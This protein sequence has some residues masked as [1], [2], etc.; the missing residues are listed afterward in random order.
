[1]KTFSRYLL[2]ATIGLLS[3]CKSDEVDFTYLPAEP[4]AGQT[5]AFNNLTEEGEEWLWEF[6]DGGESTLKNPSKTY[7]KPG[8]Y[9]ITLTADGK[10]HRKCAKEITVYDTIPTFSA[11]TDEIAYRHPV[12]FTAVAYN[13]YNNDITY[14]WQLPESAVITA[15]G[16][17]ENHV[18]VYFIEKETD[19]DITL[20]LSIGNTQNAITRSFHICDS[21]APSLLMTTGE[22][23]LRQRLYDNGTETPTSLE[24]N[25][26]PLKANTLLAQD[27]ILYIFTGNGSE[28]STIYAFDMN[29]NRL[30]TVIS[31]TEDNLS[32]EM[33]A[34]TISEGWLYWGGYNSIYRISLDTRNAV[35][36]T[37]SDYLFAET[38]PFGMTSGKT[39]GIAVCGNLWLWSTGK[40]ICRFTQTK[41]NATI[42]LADYTIN[43]LAVDALA[44]KVYF[45]ANNSLFVSNT[46]GTSVRQLTD[47]ATGAIAIDNRSNRIY[48]AQDNGIACLPLLQTQNN[49]TTAEPLQINNLANITAL[50]TDNTE[51]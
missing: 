30:S 17:T 3:A 10:A 42:L 51:R 40:G 18:T 25:A 46:D 23:L 44:R 4:R 5:I 28:K 22:G 7:K 49:Q 13:P 39:T 11:S 38:I 24:L 36:S 21:P 26:T 37:S 33:S 8:V 1:M 47:N 29:S 6:G 12:T 27:G 48:F 31:S 20:A 43:S 34:G 14:A 19:I 15:G 2:L 35:F 45:T 50:T 9:V 32:G 16:I 41:D